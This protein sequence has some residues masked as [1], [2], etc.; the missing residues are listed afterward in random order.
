M[1][2][3]DFARRALVVAEDAEAQRTQLLCL[4]TVA[5]A[6]L[7]LGQIEEAVFTY[8]QSSGGREYLMQKQL[9]ILLLIILIKDI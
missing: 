7:E 8:L 3:L 1:A 4:E 5:Q 9:L 2:T 6:Q